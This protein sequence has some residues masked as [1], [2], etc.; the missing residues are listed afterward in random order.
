MLLML[1][2]KMAERE[3]EAGGLET[4]VE[5]EIRRVVKVGTGIEG[6]G[7]GVGVR[8]EGGGRGVGVRIE[9]GGVGAG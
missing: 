1:R 6:G 7:K 5:T 3:E 4:E 9:G 8:I 2:T